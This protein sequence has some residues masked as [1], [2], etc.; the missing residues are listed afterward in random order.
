MPLFTVAIPYFNHLDHLPLTLMS[1]AT[2]TFR[3]FEVVVCDDGSPDGEK[4]KALCE[5]FSDFM[6]SP[7]RYIRFDENM[8]IGVNRQRTLDAAKGD[9]FTS[10]DSDDLMYHCEVLATYK[11][12]IDTYVAQGKVVDVLHGQFMEAHENGVR[13]PHQP[14]DGAWIHSKAYRVQFLKDNKITFPSYEF[15]ED[16]GFNHVVGKLATFQ[17]AIPDVMYLWTH[18]ANSIVRS[19]EYIYRMLPLFADSFWRAYKLTEPIKGRDNV[20]DLILNE[21]VMCYFYLQ[22][23]ERRYPE[24]DPQLAKTYKVLR[25]TIEDTKIIDR[26]NDDERYYNAF[27]MLLQSGRTGA[28]NQDPYLVESIPFNDWLVLHFNKSIKKLEMGTLQGVRDKGTDVSMF[29]DRVPR[30]SM[31]SGDYEV[32]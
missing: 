2:Q 5:K 8:K 26:I 29:A 32:H 3:D 9:Y 18:T 10:V 7:I 31:A 15:Y 1:I 6:P 21:L 22:G 30:S 28:Y 17:V 14:M 16:G 11:K 25:D 12:N 4:C 20:S 27:K 24:D 13:N 23:L 19:G